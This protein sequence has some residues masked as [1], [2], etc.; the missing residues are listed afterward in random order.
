MPG[1][2]KGP[3]QCFV[4]TLRREGVRG[5]YKGLSS[6]ITG[7]SLT[8]C[9][10]FGVYGLTRRAQLQADQTEEHFPLLSLTQIGL[11]GGAAGLIGGLIQS[12][13]ELI[14]IKLQIQTTGETRVYSGPI[15]CIKKIVKAEGMKGLTRG[16][17]AT[18][19]RDIPGFA[20]YFVVY[21]GLRRYIHCPLTSQPHDSNS[22]AC[23]QWLPT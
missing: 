8:N 12:P 23:M 7:D 5:L 11:A 14:K 6:P 20:A 9:L 15:D 19:W 16:L 22:C 4:K 1:A 17:G 10:V 13:V 2:F 18:W 21:E 3:V